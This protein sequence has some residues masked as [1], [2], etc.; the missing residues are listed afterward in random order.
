MSFLQLAVV[1][2]S[3]A[4]V[5]SKFFDCWSTA[6]HMQGPSDETNRIARAAMSRFGSKPTI[7]AIF[8]VV[9]A[10]VAIVGG[11]AYNT[12]TG[13]RT[14]ANGSALE[15]LGVWGYVVLGLLMSLVQAAVAKSNGTGEPNAIARGVQS[16]MSWLFSW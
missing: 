16:G 13:L 11:G 15:L 2:V 8:G 1:A 6:V 4:L 3:L 10:I 12:A 5:V 7:W 14:A 9:V